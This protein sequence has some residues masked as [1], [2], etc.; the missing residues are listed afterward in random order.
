MATSEQIDAAL[1]RLERA[2]AERDSWKGRSDHHYAMAAHLV[3]AL[4][5]E[6]A[7]LLSE[8]EH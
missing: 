2:K 6:L 3:A 8:G 4:E 7:R 1:A 5:K